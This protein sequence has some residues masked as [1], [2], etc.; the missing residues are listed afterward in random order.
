MK[1]T[2]TTYSTVDTGDSR[3]INITINEEYPAHISVHDYGEPCSGFLKHWGTREQLIRELEK[4]IE[5][6]KELPN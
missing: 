5:A 4:T 1:K 2:S 3:V 6:I